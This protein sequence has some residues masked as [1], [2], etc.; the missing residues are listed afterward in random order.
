MC[1][2]IRD[3]ST[4]WLFDYNLTQWLRC[5]SSCNSKSIDTQVV[6]PTNYHQKDKVEVMAYD[7]AVKVTN[8]KPPICLL[9][10]ISF[11]QRNH[12]WLLGTLTVAG[13]IKIKQTRNFFT[14]QWKLPL[15]K[16][17]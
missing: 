5:T 4:L 13:T 17:D 6:E 8:F 12:G 14:I 16:M 15:W 1:E 11:I 7:H 9:K 2:E 10:V 3:F